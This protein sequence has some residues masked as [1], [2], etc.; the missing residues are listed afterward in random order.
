M[1][2]K[3]MIESALSKNNIQLSSAQIDKLESYLYLIQQW[4][5]VFNLTAVTDLQEMVYIHLIDSLSILNYLTGTSLLDVG[6][7][8][9]LPGLP[10]AI[11]N[12]NL[13]VTL[14]DKSGKKTRFLTQMLAELNLTNVNVV[15]ARVED[16]KL[17]NGFDCIVSRA[18]ASIVQYV[19]MTAHLLKP[20]GQ[21]LAM[22][23]KYPEEEIQDLPED[24][25]IQQVVKLNIIGLTAERHLLCI[26]KK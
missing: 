9:G 22:K 19:K 13:S 12:P 15:H 24:F 3:E 18:F 4:N 17:A 21:I 10:L 20:D 8:A 5:K 6:S 25:V 1:P 2:L 26:T 23:G 16:L 7:G 11:A 14:I